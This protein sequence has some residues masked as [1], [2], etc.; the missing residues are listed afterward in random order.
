MGIF[1]FIGGVAS[2]VKDAFDPSGNDIAQFFTDQEED[3]G[4]L[5]WQTTKRAGLE[6]IQE[7]AG[8]L[9]DLGKT[10]FGDSQEALRQHA[11]SGSPFISPQSISGGDYMA[12]D[13]AKQMPSA[14]VDDYARRYSPFLE[15]DFTGVLEEPTA[16]GLDALGVYG[17]AKGAGLAGKAYTAAGRKVASM[18]PDLAA[19]VA[20]TVGRV[21]P[22]LSAQALLGA[23][24]NMSMAKLGELTMGATFPLGRKG[25]DVT[26]DGLNEY[27]TK[28]F[29]KGK[30]G[31]SFQQNDL[32]SAI[33]MTTEGNAVRGT[34]PYFQN[35]PLRPHHN[36]GKGQL[37]HDADTE[38]LRM[39]YEQQGDLM[40][41]EIRQ[42]DP[43]WLSPG[44]DEYNAYWEWILSERPEAI[45]Q[46][47]LMRNLHDM[48]RT[49]NQSELVRGFLP[50][51]LDSWGE[52]ED[53][54]A[55]ISLDPWDAE[56]RIARW[57][58]VDPISTGVMDILDIPRG[59]ITS[60]VDPYQ[61]RINALRPG[62]LRTPKNGRPSLKGI[63][64]E[65]RSG[66]PH[67]I[68][69]KNLR[70]LREIEHGGQIMEAKE[71]SLDALNQGPLGNAVGALAPQGVHIP[72]PPMNAG[73]PFGQVWGAHPT[74]DSG[75]PLDSWDMDN[76]AG[77]IQP[78]EA[79]A[80][81]QLLDLINGGQSPS[82]PSPTGPFVQYDNLDVARA[83][84]QE[85]DPHRKLKGDE[86]EAEFEKR[87]QRA[88]QE[89][90]VLDSWEAELIH[91]AA[92]PL[93][94]RNYVSEGIN[95]PVPKNAGKAEH[96][97]TKAFGESM[98]ASGDITPTLATLRSHYMGG[99]YGTPKNLVDEI[100]E[101]LADGTGELEELADLGGVMGGK[102]R[103]TL[104]DGRRYLYKPGQ[105]QGGDHMGAASAELTSILGDIARPGLATPTRMAQRQEFAHPHLQNPLAA[106]P[107]HF[108]GQIMGAN[109]EATLQPWLEGATDLEAFFEQGG[110]IT[111]A[112]ANQL[113][114]TA[115]LNA[116]G[117]QWD[118]QVGNYVLR[119]MGPGKG[120]NGG[121]Y[122][123]FP[124]DQDLSFTSGDTGMDNFAFKNMADVASG[125]ISGEKAWERLDGRLKGSMITERGLGEDDRAWRVGGPLERQ[126][127]NRGFNLDAINPDEINPQEVYVPAE[128]IAAAAP[129][130]EDIIRGI[131]AR[132]TDS[133]LQAQEIA[134]NLAP[135]VAERA[136][137]LPDF[138][139][140]LFKGRPDEIGDAFRE[141]GAA[142]VGL[143]AAL[144][145]GTAGL[146]LLYQML[147]GGDEE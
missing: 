34:V 114:S 84:I 95:A 111:P 15:G 5:T 53:I 118:T 17:A 115:P 37:A 116:L 101:A 135:K 138:M 106:S 40:P 42:I 25:K 56:S 73:A 1:D 14:I 134:D 105:N 125:K 61:R 12:D 119:Y 29:N 87:I 8:S 45:Q 19:R 104:P 102:F 132:A 55:A 58:E 23:G 143:L 39:A 47:A 30:P 140:K 26:V 59:H 92:K 21:N 81:G 141:R 121:D 20:T 144:G 90:D 139:E 94:A 98:I 70:R 32:P 65:A 13:V 71:W 100:N 124:I 24:T 28:L 16:F 64:S 103:I 129:G 88:M 48:L 60:I 77:S 91:R 107:G 38:I 80:L 49:G 76:G 109:H 11:Q 82:T 36:Q 31:V 78:G 43:T 74:I 113:L 97:P 6:G 145:G 136:R 128:N 52:K 51:T 35:R 130:I 22:N 93:F 27:V 127:P 131:F 62:N 66:G 86:L 3:P 4:D 18:N 83:V 99:P 9:M 133:P 44:S 142:D 126:D 96:I 108:W 69:D 50:H 117:G 79:D 122:A 72:T 46:Q 120:P 85:I 147:F 63:L 33:R 7:T 110:K 89:G 67:G 112:I 2:G 68:G 75:P 123:L 137:M 146:G 54:G 57:N 41:E 10:L